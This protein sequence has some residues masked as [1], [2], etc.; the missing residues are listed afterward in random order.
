MNVSQ[1]FA[2]QLGFP[3]VKVIVLIDLDI[4]I[5]RAVQDSIYVYEMLVQK[6]IMTQV[7]LPVLGV[8]ISPCV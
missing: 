1:N 4:L 6:F 3:C 2:V 7:M 8:G 5:L